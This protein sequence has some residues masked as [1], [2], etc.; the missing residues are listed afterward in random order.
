MRRCDAKGRDCIEKNSAK[1][2]NC[3]TT[4]VGIYADVQ[5]I[6]KTIEETTDDEDSRVNTIETDL[7][8]KDRNDNELLE[9]VL[10][11]LA[12]LEKGMETVKGAV[13]Q[14]GEELDK[15]KYKMLI[16]EYRK[17]KS[18]NVKHFRFSSGASSTFGE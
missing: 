6:G 18:K 11:R 17:V 1:T 4:C 13:G 5:W 7:I 10:R 14:K 3:S 8:P 15:E 12:D 9:K 16:A 2:F